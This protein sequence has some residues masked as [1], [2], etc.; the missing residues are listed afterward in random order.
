MQNQS[1]PD[2]PEI[3]TPKSTLAAALA[4]H[5]AKHPESQLVN[6]TDTLDTAAADRLLSLLLAHVKDRPAAQQNLQELAQES[7]TPGNCLRNLLFFASVRFSLKG[8]TRGT[9]RMNAL[10]E[11]ARATP[12]T[13]RDAKRAGRA[14]R[15]LDR[16]L[17]TG[18]LR[19]GE[20]PGVSGGGSY[21]STRTR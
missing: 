21:Q 19:R 20:V 2:G 9:E 15:L 11:D 17:R 16:L 7:D 5:N 10:L 18:C 6:I 14:W 12:E 3:S 8:R 1:T 13:R 4:L